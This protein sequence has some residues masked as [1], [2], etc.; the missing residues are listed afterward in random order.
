MPFWPAIVSGKAGLAAF[1]LVFVD[2]HDRSR[3]R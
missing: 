1:V 3:R 2:D